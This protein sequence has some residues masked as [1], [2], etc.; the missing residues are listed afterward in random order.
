[1]NS[2]ALRTGNT[3]GT[4]SAQPPSPRVVLAQRIR[5]PIEQEQLNPGGFLGSERGIAGRLGVERSPLCGALEFLET[6][7][8][9]RRRLGG[10]VVNDGKIIRHL[11]TIQGVP[12]ML[13]SRRGR[14]V[15]RCPV[16][17]WP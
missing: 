1:M 5:G 7:G 13:S 8:E 10:I 9:I 4:G 14:G 15:P 11:N 16:L 17:A 3:V 6:S 12:D 2:D